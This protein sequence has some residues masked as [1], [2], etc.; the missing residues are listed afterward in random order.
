MIQQN[1]PEVSVN[2]EAVRWPALEKG[3]N[4][5]VYGCLRCQL[6]QVVAHPSPEDSW[7][8]PP[9]TLGPFLGKGGSRWMDDKQPSK[10]ISGCI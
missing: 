3:V 7:V 8:G 9:T 6:V 2:L 4:L 10:S 1:H 5:G